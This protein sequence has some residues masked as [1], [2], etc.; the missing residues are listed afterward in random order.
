MDI[1]KFMICLF[2]FGLLI[3]LVY[4]G[5]VKLQNIML[6]EPDIIQ[7]AVSPDGKYVAYVYESSGGATS[8]FI[9]RLSIIKNGSKLEKGKK[10][11]Y[12]SY[13]DFK[14]YW[15]D[16]KKIIVNNKSSV[17]IFKQKYKVY[18]ITVNYKYKGDHTFSGL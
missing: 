18:D 9:Y 8:R 3:I 14:V 16:D 12:I 7:E 4:T 13:I 11:I 6:S 10:D 2:A 17:D 1:K 15:S 5:V